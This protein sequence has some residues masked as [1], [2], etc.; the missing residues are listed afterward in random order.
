MARR[1]NN[2]ADKLNQQRSE[3]RSPGWRDMISPEAQVD[4]ETES[5]EPARR[6]KTSTPPKPKTPSRNQKRRKTYYIPVR[7]IE[8]IEQIA[9]EEKVGISDL[10]T[11]LLD[12]ALESVHRG[13]LTI[14]T[15]PAKQKIDY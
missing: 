2:L 1:K 11:Y 3:G 8:E 6:R 9:A 10:A 12:A 5:T 4:T 15:R 7:I 14:P 13:D